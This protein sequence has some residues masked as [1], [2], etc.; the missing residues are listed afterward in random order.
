MLCLS[1]AVND[2]CRQTDVL[3]LGVQV[4]R[5]DRDST[6]TFNRSSTSASASGSCFDPGRM[7]VG[8]IV[9][10]AILSMQC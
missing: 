2:R 3:M 1:A 5:R 10:R 9:A 6:L 8:Y 4:Q 7:S